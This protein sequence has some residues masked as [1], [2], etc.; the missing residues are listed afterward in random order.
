M[1]LIHASGDL[2]ELVFIPGES[3]LGKT[4]PNV[5]VEI[6]L[7]GS[8]N[9]TIVDDDNTTAYFPGDRFTIIYNNVNLGY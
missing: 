8:L 7:D 6:N 4:K 2:P 1:G 9:L 3:N 5:N